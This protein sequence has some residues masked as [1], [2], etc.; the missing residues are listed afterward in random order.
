MEFL[1]ILIYS[2]LPNNVIYFTVVIKN[3]VIYVLIAYITCVIL[4]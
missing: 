4:N 1:N 2:F 3:K